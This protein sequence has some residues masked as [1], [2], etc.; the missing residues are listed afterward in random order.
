MVC[1]LF[2]HFV[3][4]FDFGYCSLAQEMSFVDHY[5]PYFRQRLVTCPLL[6]LLP[7]Q[8]LFTEVHKE[9]SS[10]PLSPSP[11]SFQPPAPSAVCQF[12][13]HCLLF[14]WGFFA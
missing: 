6:A 4:Q 1:C 7:F 5:L 2:F 14:S 11:V 13:V 10:L 3:E 8:H 9:I 12:S